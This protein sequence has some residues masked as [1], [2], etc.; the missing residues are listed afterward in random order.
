VATDATFKPMFASYTGYERGPQGEVGWQGKCI[1]CNTKL[2]VGLTGDTDATIEH[3]RP[4]CSGGHPEDPRNLALACSRCNN[5]KGVR[6]DRFAGKDPRADE[7]IAALLE[8][9]MERWR[10]PGPP[11]VQA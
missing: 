3:I 7:V 5:E 1:H 4:K 8:K 10:E 2:Y 6:H 9:R 11:T